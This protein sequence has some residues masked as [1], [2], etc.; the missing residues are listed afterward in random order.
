MSDVD[1]DSTKKSLEA[2]LRD[3][4]DGRIQL[5]DFQ[6]G[7]VWNDEGLRSVLASV[8]RSFPIGALMTLQ[9]GGTTRFKPR[10]IE[11]APEEH[12]TVQPEALLLD[13]QQRVTS[14]YQTTMRRTVVK[15]E[16][17]KRQVVKLWYYIDMAKALDP[18][19]DREE[20]FV[21]VREDRL[22]TEDFDRTVRVDLSTPEKEY[23]ACMFP[24]NRIFD[25]RDW[26]YGFEDYW[27]LHGDPDKRLFYR[28]FAD[29]VLEAFRRYQIPVIE[30]GRNTSREAVCLVFEKVNTGGKK[31]DAFELL[32]AIFASDE[33]ELRKDWYGDRKTG[34]AGIKGRLDTHD[35]LKS[36]QST[37]FLQAVTLLHT[38]DLRRADLIAGKGDDARPVLCTRDA[39]LRLPLDGYLKHRDRVEAAFRRAALFLREQ[40]IYWQRDVPYVS[41]L[42][43]LAV[44]L[45]ELGTKF[46]SHIVRQKLAQWFWCG[47]FGE[48]YGS[49]V[50]TRFARDIVDVPAWID[51]GPV[52]RT[53]N[54]AYFRAERLRTLRTRLSAAYKGFNAL[55]MKTGA[56][57]FQ[58]GQSFDD[59]VYSA[60]QLDIHHVFP[61]AW[62]EKQ[63]KAIADYDSIV[64][65]TPIGLRTNRSIGGHAP[66]VYL[67][68]LRDQGATTDAALDEHLATHGIVSAH[69]RADDFESFMAARRLA[70]LDLVA[71]A[72]GPERVERGRSAGTEPEA[73]ADL[74]DE[75]IVEAATDDAMTE[76][77]E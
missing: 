1:F 52:P 60:D 19:A 75:T 22:I 26:E 29:V 43:P 23:Q 33:H 24:A 6:R 66:S 17:A 34:T 58:S 72:I 74:D 18:R 44:I 45:A 76:A 37:D 53:M 57:D 14:L 12:A 77:A 64:N 20:A 30:L 5:P 36:V 15:T 48:L 38:L 73:D 63:G 56:R 16:N 71:N 49:A 55:L 25:A 67:A 2:I 39:L 62:C 21:A 27:R 61:K 11:G 47:V 10:L 50:E 8:S 13:G 31:L 7:W 28:R 42:V 32:T 68:R 41:Q 4:R 3:A 51:G 46:D 65:K 40:K 9:A 54:D 35:V 59:S 70:L 69:L